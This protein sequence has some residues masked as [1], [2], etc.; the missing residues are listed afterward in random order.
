MGFKANQHLT[1]LFGRSRVPQ[2]SVIRGGG[3]L[4]TGDPGPSRTDLDATPAASTTTAFPSR[5]AKSLPAWSGEVRARPGSCIRMPSRSPRKSRVQALQMTAGLMG[6]DFVAPDSDRRSAARRRPHYV[7]ASGR[8]GR[9]ADCDPH[10]LRL[11]EPATRRFL[12][13]DRTDVVHRSVVC[14]LLRFGCGDDALQP[15]MRLQ[16]R[17]G[18]VPLLTGNGRRR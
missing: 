11:S 10:R 7:V 16:R 5:H 6:A 18:A 15:V 14:P 2:R 4:A 17:R 3:R 9:G 1:M 8:L 12:V 13:L